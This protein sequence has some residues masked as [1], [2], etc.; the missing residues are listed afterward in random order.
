MN[1]LTLSMKA[2]SPSEVRSAASDN[3]ALHI[4]LLDPVYRTPDQPGETRSYDL[5]RS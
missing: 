5:A 1:G 2:A 3:G 4:L